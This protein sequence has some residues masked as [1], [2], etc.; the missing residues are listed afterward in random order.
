MARRPARHPAAAARAAPAARRRHPKRQA[1]EVL[2][3]LA[4]E[5]Q[6]L[7]SDKTDRA[8]LAALLTEMAMRLN[9]DF[10]LP[11]AE[12]AVAWLTPRPRARATAARPLGAHAGGGRSPSCARCSSGPEQRQLRAL[13]TRLD[14]PA[15]QARDVSRV[16][17]QAIAAAQRRSAPDARARA[18]HRRSDH[19]VGPAESAAARRRAVPDHR[20]GDPQGHRRHA[21]RHA[22]VAEPHARAQ[23]V[24]ARA[25]VAAHRAADGQAVRRSRPAQH[26][27]L[28]RRAGVPDPPAS[29]GCCCSTSPPG[30]RRSRTP[31]WSR[32]C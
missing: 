30:P 7:R 20:P 2:A 22:R 4:R 12:D 1:D 32:A 15:A 17:P 11:A 26:A 23:P 13:Q 3:R 16:L 27:G 14:D 6:E 21:Q 5:S 28:P 29:R 24:V 18:D 9:D 19:R 31:T 25:P 10:R 8:A